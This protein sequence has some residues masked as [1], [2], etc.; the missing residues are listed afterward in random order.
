MCSRSHSVVYFDRYLL[1]LRSIHVAA[2]AS[3]LASK[4]LYMFFLPGISNSPSPQTALQWHPI[5]RPLR[6][7]VKVS[8]GPTPKRELTGH[9]VW[10][11]VIWG[12]PEDSLVKNLPANAGDSGLTLGS[13]KIPWRRKWQPI[14]IFLSG[15]YHGQRSLA[16]Q[17]PWG[18]KRV[19]HNLATKQ[20]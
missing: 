16:S 4:R 6:T 11:D 19:G 20:Q 2:W 17:S 1:F 5:H 8:S 18:H 9:R 15:E 13:G 12:F 10:V 7:R 3:F 14:S